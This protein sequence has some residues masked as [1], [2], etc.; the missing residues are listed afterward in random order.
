MAKTAEEVGAKVEV[1]EIKKKKLSS[2]LEE[3]DLIII[4]SGIQAGR[5][6]KEP[7]KFLETNLEVL[8]KQKVALFV[9]CGDAGNPD[10]CDKA[11]MEYLDAI[12]AEHSSLFPVST[13]LFGGMFDFKRYNFA[14]RALV[15][16][17]VKKRAPEG[18]EVPEIMDFRDWDKI[19]EWITD[20]V[21]L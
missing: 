11:Q 20:V 1:V 10:M 7:L 19:R 18:E 14:T 6:T 17:I 5:W 13:G 2:A 8:S 16:S 15:K 21:K 12:T 4:G 9:V 3:Y